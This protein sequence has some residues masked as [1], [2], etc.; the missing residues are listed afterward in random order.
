MLLLCRGSRGGKKVK[1]VVIRHENIKP[2]D[3]FLEFIVKNKLEVIYIDLPDTLA[4]IYKGIPGEDWWRWDQESVFISK[5]ALPV[6]SKIKDQDEDSVFIAHNIL[7]TLALPEN[8]KIFLHLHGYPNELN[9]ACKLILSNKNYKLISVSKRIRDEFIKLT[10][11][12]LDITVLRN[13]I[14]SEKFFKVQKP[15]KI[16][17]LFL[18]RLIS[19]KGI[20]EFLNA[21]LILKKDNFLPKI[22]IGGQGPLQNEIINFITLNKLPNVQFIGYVDEKEKNLLYNSSRLCCFPSL[23]KEGTLLTMLEASATGTPVLTTSGSSMEEFVKDEINGF[24]TNPKDENEFANKIKNIL[25]KTDEDLSRIGQR[26]LIEVNSNWSLAKT[27]KE[28][29]NIYENI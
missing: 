27:V 2:S 12:N 14:D 21:V 5:L 7:D 29:I 18:G 23:G 22:V 26:A 24:L 25:F 3:F 13:S 28:L 11:E 1:L 4:F 9:Y 8:S 17:V 6:I 19:N 15:K 16:D 20:M 10:K